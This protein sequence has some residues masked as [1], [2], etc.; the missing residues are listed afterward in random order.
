MYKKVVSELERGLITF[1]ESK[2]K[3]AEMLM[4]DDSIESYEELKLI[5]LLFFKKLA[6]INVGLMEEG[7]SQRS[8]DRARRKYNKLMKE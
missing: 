2:S 3:I 5:N 6:R 4:D 1:D 7:T 8:R